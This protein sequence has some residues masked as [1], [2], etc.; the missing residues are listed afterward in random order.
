MITANADIQGFSF[1][2]SQR[3]VKADLG[4]GRDYSQRW[5]SLQVSTC[6]RQGW[7]IL[8]AGYRGW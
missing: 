3:L 7:S 6:M 4:G 2:P 1:S 8:Y 5:L